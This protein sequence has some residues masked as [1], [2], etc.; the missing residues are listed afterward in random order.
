MKQCWSNTCVYSSKGVDTLQVNNLSRAQPT[1]ASQWETVW[2]TKSNFL[3]LFLKSDK[4]QWD[5][6]IGNYYKA[7][8]LQEY[9]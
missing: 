1:H 8:V 9:L 6:E 4:D 5:C 7:L 2:L 3:G